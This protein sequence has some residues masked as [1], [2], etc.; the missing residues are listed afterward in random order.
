[1]TDF[2]LLVSLCTKLL[3]YSL[4]INVIKTMTWG[5]QQLFVLQPHVDLQHIS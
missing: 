1:M 2:G 5:L 3:K 4:E